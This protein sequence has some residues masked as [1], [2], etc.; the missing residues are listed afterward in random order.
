[1]NRNNA[2][3]ISAEVMK[4]LGKLEKKLGVSF[5]RGNGKFDDNMFSMKITA[6]ANA[7]DGSSQS[8]EEVDFVSSAFRFG[9]KKEDLGKTFT[10]NGMSFKICGLKPKSRKYPVLAKNMMG[11]VYKF[12]ASTTGLVNR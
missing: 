1:M 3:D 8:K 10:A 12:A 7:S 5:S 4:A 6:T 11:K 2:K 9:L